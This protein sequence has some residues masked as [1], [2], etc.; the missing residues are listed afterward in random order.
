[1]I[2]YEIESKTHQPIPDIVKN[3]ARQILMF[4]K[5]KINDML[6]VKKGGEK[7]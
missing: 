6:S 4:N 1:M 3:V 7:I 2:F 5:N